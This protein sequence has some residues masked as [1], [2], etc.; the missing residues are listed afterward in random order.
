MRPSAASPTPTGF[1]TS[2]GTWRAALPWPLLAPCVS[3]GRALSE[4]GRAHSAIFVDE[5]RVG[6]L[7]GEPL[8]L[9]EALGVLLSRNRTTSPAEVWGW[10][11]RSRAAGL[12]ADAPESLSEPGPGVRS[13]VATLR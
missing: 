7:E 11:A 9:D 5:W 10:L 2:M 1:S 4:A 8:I 13:A 3:S 12:G 6:F